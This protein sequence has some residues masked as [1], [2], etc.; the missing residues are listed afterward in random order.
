MSYKFK[1]TYQPALKAIARSLV[2]FGYNGVTPDQIDKAH[3]RWNAG[4]EPA[5][6]IERFAF[7]DFDE[8]PAHF[9]RKD[10]TRPK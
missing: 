9:G 6:I 8:H 4:Y 5:N 7:K 1:P 2:E 3:A 10:G